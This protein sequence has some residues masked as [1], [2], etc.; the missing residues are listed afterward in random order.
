MNSRELFVAA[1]RGMESLP[2]LLREHA[3][4]VTALEEHRFDQSYIVFLD[5]QIRLNPR[6]PDWTERLRHRRA[7]LLP[8]TGVTLLRGRVQVA[9]ADF[10]VEIHPESK[11]VVHWEA[12]APVDWK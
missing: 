3:A 11:A 12:Y 8:F 6:G 2:A 5:E 7:E 4:E 10:T 1:V 9:E